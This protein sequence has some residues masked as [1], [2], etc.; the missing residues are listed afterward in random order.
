MPGGRKVRQQRQQ[1][2]QRQSRQPAQRQAQ[3]KAKIRRELRRNGLPSQ[4][5]SPRGKAKIQQVQ[6]PGPKKCHQ[7]QR[8][9]PGHRPIIRQGQPV[10]NRKPGEPGR[11]ARDPKLQ[12]APRRGGKEQEIQDFPSRLDGVFP[13][14]QLQAAGEDRQGRRQPSHAGAQKRNPPLPGQQR[15]RP[16][17]QRQGQ[18]RAKSAA[19][20]CGRGNT[21]GRQPTQGVREQER[22][23]SGDLRLPVPAA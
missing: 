17:Q 12:H 5:Q 2:Q 20:V 19:Q 11:L 15:H 10:P 18:S 1:Q 6:R 8:Q 9:K 21:A 4:T 23:R 16:R 7:K 14:G 13:K 22:H 3:A